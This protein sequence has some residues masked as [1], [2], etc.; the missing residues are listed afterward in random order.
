MGASHRRV[1]FLFL[2]RLP[3]PHADACAPGHRKS[4]V[5]AKCS[6][7]AIE[8]MPTLQPREQLAAR[9]GM[10]IINSVCSAGLFI[11]VTSYQWARH[12]KLD[13]LEEQWSLPAMQQQLQLVRQFRQVLV[14]CSGL[15]QAWVRV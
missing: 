9:I 13:R 6:Y 3:G 14:L 12:E 7:V 4:Q 2:W 5:R 11:T 10:A 15:R 8:S 1:P